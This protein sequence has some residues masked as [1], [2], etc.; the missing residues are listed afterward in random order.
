MSRDSSANVGPFLSAV[1]SRLFQGKGRLSLDIWRKSVDDGV[2][3]LVREFHI[4]LNE[5]LEWVRH[6][7][8]QSVPIGF[9]VPIDYWDERVD[10]EGILI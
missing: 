1:G 10:N 2:Y 4:R 8:S 5:P 7:P 3:V 6:P 9:M